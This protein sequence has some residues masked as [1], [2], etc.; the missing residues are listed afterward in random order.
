MTLMGLINNHRLPTVAAARYSWCEERGE[1]AVTLEQTNFHP[2][3]KHMYAEEY[4]AGIEREVVPRLSLKVQYLR[5]N[6]RDT[7]G[8][9]DTG[10]TWTPAEVTDPGPDG[11]AGTSDD[12]P[13]MTVYYNDDPSAARYVLTNPPGAWRR[14]DAVQIAAE[15]RH[16][17]GWSMQASYTGARTIGSFDNDA[18]SNAASSDLAFNGN[19]AN[20]NRAILSTGRTAHDR[21]HDLKVLGTYVAPRWDIRVSGLYRV[22]SG[23][24]YAR[25]LNTF[26][27]GTQTFPLT[28]TSM[29]Y[30][31]PV[32]TYHE[33]AQAGAD[34]RIEKVLRLRSANL[35][36]Y[37]D[38]YN[39]TNRIVAARTNNVSGSSFGQTRSFSPPREFR[40]GL[41]VVF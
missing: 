17:S 29:I 8:Y 24:P 18:A 10:S 28:R 15:R 13:L 20:P 38:L 26:G 31:T 3:V 14:Y 35:G 7:L 1:C 4:F 5:R 39:V 11:R 12:G 32:G 2:D 36:L 9:V 6:T 19:F 40:A 34:I 25:I 21:R 41:R 22:T 23:T 33:R 30:A 16:A 37:G 27:P